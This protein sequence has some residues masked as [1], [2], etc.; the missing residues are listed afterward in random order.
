MYKSVFFIGYKR[1]GKNWD[2]CKGQEC[3][4]QLILK[5]IRKQKYT[6]QNNV[7]RSI[8]KIEVQKDKKA[9]ESI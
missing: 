9:L 1:V 6:K 3:G 4:A 7:S 8:K 5:E 2:S